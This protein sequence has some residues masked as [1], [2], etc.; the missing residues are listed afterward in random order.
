MLSNTLGLNFSYLTIIHIPRPRYHSKI[1]RHILNNKQK[2]KRVF[3]L[4]ITRLIM[5]KM[6]MKMKN[7]SHRY[8]KNRPRSRHGYKF[9]K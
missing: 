2:N 4:E 7:I 5:M 8:N 6:K 3:I 9:S 1:R